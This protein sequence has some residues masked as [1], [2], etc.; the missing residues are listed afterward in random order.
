MIS[1]CIPIFNFDV[2]QLLD[3]L[4]SQSKQI[5]VP[6]EIILIDDCS[7]EEFK[8]INE[9]NCKKHTY[10]ELEQN[11]GRA[12]IR[13]QFL[14]YAQ[15]ENL[16]FL[17]CDSIIISKDFLS[18]YLVALK[19]GSIGVICGGRIYDTEKPGR[20]KM[21]RWKYGKIR[22][23]QTFETRKLS[24]NNSFMTNNFLIKRKIFKELKFEERITEYGHEDTLFGFEL[25]KRGIGIQHI[26]N[27]VLNG[28]VEE[29]AEYLIKTEKGIS[30]LINVL[31]YTGYDT[32][33]IQ[34]V[35]ILRTYERL[36]SKGLLNLIYMVFILSKPMLKFLFV[37][38]YVNLKLFDF[39]KLGILI[40]GIK[41]S[42]V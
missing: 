41:L 2:S 13:N 6:F 3:K 40:Q 22:E 5:D 14:E 32:D 16:L 18:N 30:S 21:L 27:P 26:N 37:H 20:N 4:S 1:V 7:S 34:D 25:K 33:F 31:A 12:K 9:S 28:D 24:P 29:N 17:D 11:I 23:S 8:K 10:I 15:Y 36:K 38:G 19:K 42:K 39:Y 35:T